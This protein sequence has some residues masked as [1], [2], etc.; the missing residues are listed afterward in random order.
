MATSAKTFATFQEARKFAKTN[1]ITSNNAWMKFKDRPENLPYDPRKTYKSSFD[2]QKID[3]FFYNVETDNVKEVVKH[4]APAG[5]TKTKT[6][7]K[8]QTPEEKM[9]EEVKN[10]EPL[11]YLQHEPITLDQAAKMHPS[12]K[13]NEKHAKLSDRYAL[14]NTY[15]VIENIQKTEP[16]WVIT[17]VRSTHI[18]KP[19]LQK[20]S[21]HVVKLESDGHKLGKEGKLQIVISNSHNGVSKFEFFF[22]I[23]RKVCTNGMVIQHPLFNGI[24]K[25]H[26][27]DY[28]EI[29]A[30]IVEAVGRA[31]EIN[32]I[33]D[34]MCERI[35]TEKEKV[36]LAI[37]GLHSRYQYKNSY[38]ELAYDTLKERYNIKELFVPLRE[39]DNGDD[40]WHVFNVIQEKV[41][42]GDYYAK[43]DHGPSKANPIKNT[44]CDL[45]FNKKFWS[46]AMELIGE[47]KVEEVEE[48]PTKSKKA[49]K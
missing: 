29:N 47:D 42:R 20:Y 6:T 9:T 21:H 36:D 11:P 39:L 46:Y 26:F 5:V 3:D 30:Y 31:K 44:H 38:L 16:S 45:Q 40:L 41:T 4:T 13:C 15:K 10:S 34:K 32:R 1:K 49:K 48:T 22:G 8:E 19:E 27:T 37:K 24:N 17:Q 23:F 18:R 28:E 12:I 35:L 7:K 33:Y 25:K 14:V 43:T 2:D